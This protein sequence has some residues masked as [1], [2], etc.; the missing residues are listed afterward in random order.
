MSKVITL[1]YPAKCKVCQK[2][3]PAFARAVWYGS[4]R[5]TAHIECDKPRDTGTAQAAPLQTVFN[6]SD[7][8]NDYIKSAQNGDYSMFQVDY[9]RK[10]WEQR[11]ADRKDENS[12][13]GCTT[14]QMLDWLNTGYRVPGLEGVDA[15][16]IPASPRK[17]ISY[18]DEGDEMMIDMILAGESEFFLVREKQPTKPSIQVKIGVSFSASIPAKV[19][20]SYQS[21]VARMLRTLDGFGLDVQVDLE[22]AGSGQ[23]DGVRAV[24][25]VVI[26]VKESGVASNFSSW[27]PM[28]SPG[29]YRHLTFMAIMQSADRVGKRYGFGLG[30]PKGCDDWDITYDKSTNVLQVSNSNS[31]ADFPE[32]IMTSKLRAILR[33]ITGIA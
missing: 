17:R 6:Y 33:G 20:N 32:W 26:R 18:Q 13:T 28:F 1:R 31:S 5:G 19:V 8:R 21:W 25:T 12:F 7:L 3:I 29:G 15:T 24:H 10:G 9:N 27:S 22:S 23:I 30:S 11:V 14:A 2:E 4:K 16:L